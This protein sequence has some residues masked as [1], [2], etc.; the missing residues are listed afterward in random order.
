MTFRLRNENTRNDFRPFLK[1]RL[2][3][4]E[5]LLERLTF[6]MTDEKERQWKFS[7]TPKKMDNEKH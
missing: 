3:E 4:D 6:A 5:K 2:L 1:E 7:N